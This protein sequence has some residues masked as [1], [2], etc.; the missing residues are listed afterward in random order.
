MTSPIDSSALN[1]NTQALP[2][3]AIRA[4]ATSGPMMRE[5]FMDTPLSASAAGNWG[6]GTSS[7]TMAENT[8]LIAPL[9][10]FSVEASLSTLSTL[11]GAN[12]DLGVA[13][14]VAITL[15]ITVVA[16]LI[17]SR[18]ASKREGL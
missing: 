17:A 4:P 12:P 8:G 1:R 2:A 18:F 7:G 14:L 15:L 9:T 16:R 10:R 13:V 3:L 5:A 6:R 11:H